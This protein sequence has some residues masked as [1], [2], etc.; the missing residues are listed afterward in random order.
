MW[1]LLYD[2]QLSLRDHAL[3]LIRVE[4]YHDQIEYVHTYVHTDRH[5][6][7]C[8]QIIKCDTEKLRQIKRNKTSFIQKS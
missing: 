3:L 4:T 1:R 7:T 6:H 8:M 2:W 5:T